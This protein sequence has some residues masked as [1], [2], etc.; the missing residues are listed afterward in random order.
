MQRFIYTDHANQRIKEREIS[1][2]QIEET[3]LHPDKILKT[4]KERIMVHKEFKG[5]KMEV[6]Y[7]KENS[8][9]IIITAYW[10]KEV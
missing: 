9:I 10:V 8:K 2:I 6:I 3:I 4:F 1:K 7:R 5:K